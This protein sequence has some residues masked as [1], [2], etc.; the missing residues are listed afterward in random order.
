MN[1]FPCKFIQQKCR[2]KGPIN[3]KFGFEFIYM[4]NKV[5]IFCVNMDLSSVKAIDRHRRE[6]CHIR[7]RERLRFSEKLLSPF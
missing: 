7:I 2:T 4:L 3:L 1:P 6:I 5:K